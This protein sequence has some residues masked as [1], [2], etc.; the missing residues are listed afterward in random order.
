M[1]RKLHHDDPSYL[2]ELAQV[3][4]EKI[5]TELQFIEEASEGHLTTEQEKQM[6]ENSIIVLQHDSKIPREI[7]TDRLNIFV[8]AM[9]DTLRKLGIVG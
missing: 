9:D 5:A 6:I 8:M 1:P 2:E 7:S 3:Q 4:A